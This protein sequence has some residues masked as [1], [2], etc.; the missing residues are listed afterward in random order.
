MRC[1]YA[2]VRLNFFN[3]CNLWVLF[4][5]ACKQFLQSAAGVLSGIDWRMSESPSGQ[6][7]GARSPEG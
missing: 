3:L 2:V 5:L 7:L 4:A 1:A 6:L